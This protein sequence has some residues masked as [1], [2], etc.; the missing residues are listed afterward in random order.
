MKNVGE[1]PK[2]YRLFPDSDKEAIDVIRFCLT[3]EEYRGYLKGNEL[4]YRLRIGKKDDPIKELNKIQDYHNELE[5][6]SDHR[7]PRAL[8]VPKGLGTCCW[9]YPG[10]GGPIMDLDL[11]VDC[12]KR[13]LG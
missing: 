5:S 6:L 1:K 4:K 7:R 12:V 2:H 8:G 13:H 11:S 10:T 3:P 9:G